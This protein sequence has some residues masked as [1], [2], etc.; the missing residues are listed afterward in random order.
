MKVRL[1]L[2]PLLC[3]SAFR[4]AAAPADGAANDA[5]VALLAKEGDTLEKGAGV[6]T[7]EN[8]SESRAMLRWPADAAGKSVHILLEVKDD[9]MPALTTYRRV[10]IEGKH[11]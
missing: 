5:V 3:G 4:V 6:V 7:L 11:K 2:L 9:G 10:I 8:G 1:L